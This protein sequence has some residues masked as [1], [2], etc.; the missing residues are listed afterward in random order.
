V[1]RIVLVALLWAGCNTCLAF[2]KPLVVC[3]EEQ[4][5]PY[6]SRDGGTDNDIALAVADSLGLPLVIHWYQTDAGDEGNP[7]LLVNAL[8]SDGQCELA[9]GFALTQNNFADPG[10]QQFSIPGADGERRG[11]ALQPLAPSLAYHAQAFAL[12]W[13]GTQQRGTPVDLDDLHGL[14]ILVEENS[15]ADLLLM[16]H[17]NG[18]LRS[19]IRHLKSGGDHLFSQLSSGK[20][21]GGWVAQHRFEQWHKNHA[22]TKLQLSGFTHDLTINL[23]FATLKSNY[24]LLERI[25]EAIEALLEDQEISLIFEHHGLS[26]VEPK[27]PQL[28]P[29]LS[30]RLFARQPSSN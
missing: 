4:S 12:I 22:D 7:A 30:T 8:L 28:M 11:V 20:H 14:S 6:S 19:S 18:D 16:A 15:V 5:L 17:R 9:G 21:D 2:G 25:D 13:P 10:Q 3:L 27:P 24:Q 23:G 26:H 29:P 1:N